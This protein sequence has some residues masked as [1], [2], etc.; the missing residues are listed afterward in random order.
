[1]LGEQCEKHESEAVALFFK[2]H[3]L[4]VYPQLAKDYTDKETKYVLHVSWYQK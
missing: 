2:T 3:K 4:D 1:M